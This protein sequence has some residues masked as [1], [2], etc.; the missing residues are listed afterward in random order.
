MKK[1]VFM[2]GATG[3]MGMEAVKRFA[4]HPDEVELYALARPGQKNETKLAPYADKIHI[5][6]GDLTDFDLLTESVKDMDYVIHIGAILPPMA[7]FEKPEYVMRTNYGSTLALLRGI[8]NY[9]QEEQTHFVYIGT[10]EEVG[11]RSPPMHWGRIG[12]PMQPPMNCYYAVSKVASERAVAESNLKYW[13]ITRQSFQHPNNPAAADYPIIAMQPEENCSE[14]IDCESSG[15][16]M[17]QIVLNAPD[18]FWCSAYNMGGGE[19]FRQN[20]YDYMKKMHGSSRNGFEPKWIAKMN[21]HGHFFLDSDKLQELV[22]YRLKT[23]EQFFG[24]EL[25]YQIKLVKSKPRLTPEQN[26]ERT[27]EICRMQG[28]T[29][30]VVE[31]NDEEGI[32]IFWGSRE[33]YDAIPDSWDDVPPPAT[34]GEPV[35]MDHGYDETKPL[36]ELAL[37]DMQQAAAF[38]GGKC[39]SESMETGAMYLPLRWQCALGHEFSAK[40]NTVLKLGHWCPECMNGQWDYFTQAKVNPFFAQSWDYLHTE[41]PFTVKMECDAKAIEDLFN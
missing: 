30:D 11:H 2:T 6:W 28:G 23:P 13:A 19:G 22:P 26:K 8:K 34:P 27:R 33:A 1:K 4:E 38:R 21:Y 37:E 36:S 12:D 3:V 41:E 31:R 39:L 17:V 29:L 5:V 18:E 32:K 35:W 24:D 16:L 20:H 9:A 10:I 15:N 40:P 14:H 7:S 25:R